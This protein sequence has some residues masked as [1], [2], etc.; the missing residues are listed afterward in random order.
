MCLMRFLPQ[1]LSPP[2]T[3]TFLP[4]THFRVPSSLASQVQRIASRAQGRRGVVVPPMQA[5]EVREFFEQQRCFSTPLS[6][7]NTPSV[8]CVWFFGILW[9]VICLCLVFHPLP[10]HHRTYSQYV[11]RRLI[12]RLLPPIRTYLASTTVVASLVCLGYAEGGDMGLKMGKN[13]FWGGA[14]ND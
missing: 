1:L 5:V 11:H 13:G 7:S 9:L 4:S 3:T 14:A 8:L 6:I 2:T 10:S 12:Y